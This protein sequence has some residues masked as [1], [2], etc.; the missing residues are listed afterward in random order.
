MDLSTI[1]FHELSPFFMDS[2]IFVAEI[3]IT[4]LFLGDDFKNKSY[5]GD[6]LNIPVYFLNRDHGWS[7][8]KFKN[9]IAKSVRDVEKN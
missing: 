3:N 7:T 6:N 8:T 1:F 4:P 2:L 9:L 5:T